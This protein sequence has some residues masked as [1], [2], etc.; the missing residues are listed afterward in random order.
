MGTSSNVLLLYFGMDNGLYQ[1]YICHCSIALYAF[2]N[3]SNDGAQQHKCAHTYFQSYGVV[4]LY[5]A[6]Y[7]GN[8]PVCIHQSCQCSTLY[9]R[10]LHLFVSLLSRQVFARLG[11]LWFSLSWSQQYSVGA[12]TLLCPNYMDTNA[13]TSS[14]NKCS[15]LYFVYI[16]SSFTKYCCTQCCALSKRMA[17]GGAPFW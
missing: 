14:G 9:S 16:W 1:R 17:S 3:L 6:H 13:Y 10:F 8:F 11:I 7:Y 4:L 12:D 5:G 15:Q 2:F